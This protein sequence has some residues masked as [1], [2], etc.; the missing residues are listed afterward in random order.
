MMKE[1]YLTLL[2]DSSLNTF[3]DNKQS[4]FTVRLDHPIQIDKDNW[5][6]GLVEIITPS[7]VKNVTDENNFFFLRFFDKLLSSKLDAAEFEPVCRE[8]ATC[9]DMKLKVPTGY[10]ST[11]QHLIEEIHNTINERYSTTLRNSNASIRIEYGINNARVK[12]NFQD[13]NRVKLI[14][15]TPLAE[16]LGVTQNTS[17]NRLVMK[18]MLSHT[19]SI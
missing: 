10:Y 9:I 13:P 18:N 4:S 12:T 19:V 1:F 6:V 16:K 15:P 2:S 8:T 14:L 5:E 3:V 11:A 7:E 17:I